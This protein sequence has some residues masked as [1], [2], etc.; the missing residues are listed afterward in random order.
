MAISQDIQRRFAFATA[1]RGVLMLLAGL[2][3]F[4]WPAQ[5]LTIMVLAGGILI[6]VL[7]FGFYLTPELVGGPS[8]SL[9]GNLIAY[10]F[11][12]SL[13]WGLAGA[14]ATMLLLVI[15]AAALLLRA[16]SPKPVQKS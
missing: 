15:A 3:V 10:N 7:S 13:N 6:F 4:I 12:K 16:V 2:Y 11:S 8:G 9:I 1:L 14:L 5:A